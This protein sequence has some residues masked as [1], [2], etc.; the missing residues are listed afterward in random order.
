[1]TNPFRT[2]EISPNPFRTA[3]TASVVPGMG[4]GMTEGVAKSILQG[5]SFGFGDEMLAGLK[6]GAKSIV[7]DEDFKGLYETEVGKQRADLE[8]FKRDNPKT[9]IASE[10]LGAIP[11]ALAFPYARGATMAGKVLG[12]TGIG[13]SAGALYGIGTGEGDLADRAGNAVL[14]TAIGGVGGAMGTVIGQGIGKG[15]ERLAR[16]RSAAKAGVDENVHDVLKE[17]YGADAQGAAG[18]MSQAG[19]S[20]MMADAGPNTMALLDVAIQKSGP[21]S[22]AARKAIDDRVT[23]ASADVMQAMD[24][25]LGSP[26]GVKT[27]EAG[28]RNKTRTPV[29]AAYDTAYAQP[30]DYSSAAGKQIED[31]ISNRV[32]ASAIRAANKLMRAEDT[33][34]KQILIKVADDGTAS[35]ETLPDVR[36][37]DYIT[38]GLNQIADKE[39]GKGALGGT[40]QL[41]RVYGNLSRELRALTKDAVPEYDKALSMAAEPISARNAL[42][43]GREALT[44][45]SVSELKDEMAG[46]TPM[47][48]SH[49]AQ[50]VREYIDENISKVQRAFTD[51]NM[52]A[53]EAAK[54]LK[55]LSSRSAR[56]KLTTIVGKEK[57]D[58]MFNTLDEAT[59][60]F[61]LKAAVAQ[62]SKTFARENLTRRVTE[63]TQYGPLNSLRR[64]YP[65]QAVREFVGEQFGGSPQ[66]LA[67]KE[68]EIYSNLVNAL[69]QRADP[70]A[71]RRM[72]EAN[73]PKLAG[74]KT[75][76]L[77]GKLASRLPLATIPMMQ[78][79]AYLR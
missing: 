52:D 39:A 75:S 40:T 73:T 58:V 77:A 79:A 60:A 76:V 49:V 30:I 50:G 35:F 42:T 26:Q 22:V 25:A 78:G 65:L 32:P 51:A 1:M 6:A 34:S 19:E 5:L 10:V 72:V 74:D 27:I 20:A 16:K 3:H 66:A 24:D 37:L 70:M 28:L 59:S 8:Q 29:S 36:Q 2:E 17:T 61:E 7:S 69:T 47:E 38:R 57:A 46:M 53:R 33:R 15:V 56:D 13:A 9:A 48:R 54:A 67:A 64:G 31:I 62:N 11:T 12:N 43:L 23:V 45:R 44:K 55:Q 14:P 21:A 71:L 63:Q 4:P 18:R 68:D 41:G